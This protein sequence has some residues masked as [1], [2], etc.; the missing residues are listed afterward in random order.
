[1][2]NNLEHMCVKLLQKE[3]FKKTAEATG[4]LI[5]IKIADKIPRAPKTSPKNNL[6]SNEEKILREKYISTTLSQKI[7]EDLRL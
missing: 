3:S 2:L 4:D 1:M 5:G 7:I 6:E